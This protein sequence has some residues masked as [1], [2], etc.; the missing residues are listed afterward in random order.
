MDE[1]LGQVLDG[2]ETFGLLDTTIIAFT[3]DHG[4]LPNRLADSNRGFAT[5][6]LPYR[7]GKGHLYEGGLRV[8]FLIAYPPIIKGV[9][10]SNAVAL[11]TDLFPTLL[12][13]TGNQLLPTTHA[14]G[15]SL[16]TAL[17]GEP[18]TRDKPIIWRSPL[19]RPDQ[20]GDLAASA[21]RIG[22]RKL[23]KHYFPLSYELYDL[24]ED[25]FETTNLA[26]KR[27]QDVQNLCKRLE[28]ILTRHQAMEPRKDWKDKTVTAPLAI[29]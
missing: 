22:D 27:P 20:T 1:S 17:R 3:S 28:S 23:V 21:I 19:P 8:P 25:P 29:E 9:S 16:A 18:Q 14:D 26:S 15:I 7:A 11:G 6:K 4:G 10:R 12:E 24:S 5:S 13:L 2:L